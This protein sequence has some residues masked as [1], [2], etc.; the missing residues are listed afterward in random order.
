MEQKIRILIVE[1]EE[2]ILQ[3]LEAYLKKEGYEVR[4]AT[5]GTKALAIFKTEEIHL[6][7]LD[8]MLPE[9]SGEEVCKQI[10]GFSTIP[11]LML[12]AR[13]EEDD[14]LTGLAIGADDYVTKPFSPREIVG[15]VKALLRRS[16]REYKP[17]A[18]QLQYNDRELEVDINRVEVRVKG[19]LVNFTPNEFRLLTVFLSHPGQ[20]FTREQLVQ[21]V[22]GFDYDGFDRT[23]DT[24][25]KNIRQKIERDPKNPIYIQTIY[26]MG[27]KFGGAK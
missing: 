11:I 19:K 8:L 3:V 20:V 27:Y 12:T 13:T 2:K 17:L 6:L 22:F 1:D 4:T 15:R 23:I 26:G 25:I 14:K 16:Y 18:E 9:M 10:R 7:I 5:D 24:H 21:K